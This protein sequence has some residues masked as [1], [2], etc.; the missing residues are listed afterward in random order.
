MPR[1][2]III[3]TLGDWESLETT[4]V[5]VLQ[6]RPPLSEVIVVLNRTYD[7]PYDLEGEVRFVEV[8]G[9]TPSK[10]RRAGL[11]EL[12]NTGLAA[13]DSELLHVL[14]CGMTVGDGWT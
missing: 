1:L 5:S 13:A 9:R 4:L 2:S 14:S 10:H 6:N 8:P 11:V 3:P 7:D 12:V